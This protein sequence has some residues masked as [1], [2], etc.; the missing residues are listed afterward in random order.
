[1]SYEMR[2]MDERLSGHREGIEQGREQMMQEIIVKKVRE[3]RKYEEIAEF[4]DMTV[5]EV[6]ALAERRDILD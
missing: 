2:L 5:D 1:M 6:A 3:G 4:L